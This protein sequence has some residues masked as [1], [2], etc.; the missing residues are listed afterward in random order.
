[1]KETITYF[2]KTGKENT[3][4]VLNL[5]RERAN[6]RLDLLFMIY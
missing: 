2:E 4:E 5:V 3:D 1:M 6:A